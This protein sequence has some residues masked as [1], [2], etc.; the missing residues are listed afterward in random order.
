MARSLR[1]RRGCL[2]FRGRRWHD[3]WYFR[4]HVKPRIPRVPRV[5]SHVQLGVANKGRRGKQERCASL[6]L[7][8]YRR[9]MAYCPS[10]RNVRR[11]ADRN[12]I[13]SKSYVQSK[14]R[15]GRTWSLKLEGQIE[16]GGH[17]HIRTWQWFGFGA[18]RDNSE[19]WEYWGFRRIPPNSVEFGEFGEMP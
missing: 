10:E 17:F 6:P 4:T 5:H 7:Y 12:K 1:L 8:V 19:R 11:L 18:R 15:G 14:F 2:Q 9:L 13:S 3:T 16:S